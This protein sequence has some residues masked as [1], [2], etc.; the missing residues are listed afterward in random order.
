V[1]LPEQLVQLVPPEQLALLELEQQVPQDLL[2]QA[3]LA[4]LE[5]PALQEQVVLLVHKAQRV[6][7]EPLVLL[8]QVVLQAILVL[9]DRLEQD[10][11]VLLVL[12]VLLQQHLDPAEQL[13]PQVLKVPLDHLDQLAPSEQVALLDH[14]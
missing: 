3:I 13:A 1:H 9:P 8:E 2:A 7:L 6:M 4:L 11:Q 10:R 12:L 14:Q 5:P